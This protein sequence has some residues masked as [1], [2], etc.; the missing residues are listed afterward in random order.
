MKFN[1][2]TNI[3]W[4]WN[5]PHTSCKYFSSEIIEFSENEGSGTNF[6]KFSHFLKSLAHSGLI[7]KEPAKLCDKV[8]PP[9]ALILSQWI[10]GKNAK[11]V[12][13][14]SYFTNTVRFRLFFRYLLEEKRAERWRRRADFDTVVKGTPLGLLEVKLNGKMNKSNKNVQLKRKAFKILFK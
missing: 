7:G 8:F 1:S 2:Y 4:K 12:P 9:L 3:Y 10:P 11:V 5:W 13:D 6:V 14:W